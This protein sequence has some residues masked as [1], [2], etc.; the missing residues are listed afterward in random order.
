MTEFLSILPERL[1]ALS[2]GA[3][4]YRLVVILIVVVG[5][6]GIG[7]F[8]WALHVAQQLDALRLDIQQR[9][10][11]QQTLEA[12]QPLRSTSALAALQAQ[13]AMY[14]VWR[15]TRSEHDRLSELVDLAGNYQLETLQLRAAPERQASS[16]LFSPQEIRQ[17]AQADMPLEI[18][19]TA[20]VGSCRE[21]PK[22]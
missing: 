19:S 21:A 1:G 5:G 6:S 18:S 15:S 12:Q 7:A 17:L 20:I 2:A 8:F 13:L 10:S 11:M 14:P 4:A 3:P 9:E 22:G 16:T